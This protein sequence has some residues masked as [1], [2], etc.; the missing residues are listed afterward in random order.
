[1][2]AAHLRGRNFRYSTV[3]QTIFEKAIDNAFA[4]L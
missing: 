2:D 3:E 4:M 1:M